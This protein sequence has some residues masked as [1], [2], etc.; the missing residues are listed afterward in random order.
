[1]NATRRLGFGLGMMALLATVISAGLLEQFSSKCEECGGRGVIVHEHA[2]A[3]DD[4]VV[5]D[6]SLAE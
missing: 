1:M 3:A 5:E 2:I 6:F 4:L